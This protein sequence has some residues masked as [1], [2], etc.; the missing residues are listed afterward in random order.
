MLNRVLNRNKE[1]TQTT[2]HFGLKI[3]FDDK[4]RLKLHL[5]DYQNFFV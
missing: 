4:G 3:L 5:P 1:N 2:Y